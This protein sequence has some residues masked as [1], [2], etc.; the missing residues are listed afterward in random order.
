MTW[1]KD[2]TLL[3]AQLGFERHPIEKKKKSV[4]GIMLATARSGI[5][6]QMQKTW[7]WFLERRSKSMML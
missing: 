7:E 3:M 5:S 4:V 2:V 6:L 1:C